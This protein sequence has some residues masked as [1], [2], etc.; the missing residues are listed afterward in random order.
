MKFRDQTS[1]LLSVVIMLL[2][3]PDNIMLNVL[4]IMPSLER[5]FWSLNFIPSCKSA[6][7]AQLVERQAFNLNVQGSSPCSGG[8]IFF[9]FLIWNKMKTKNNFPF[10]SNWFRKCNNFSGYIYL[11][12]R[13]QS[14][15]F[16]FNGRICL[17][18]TFSQHCVY[19]I[20]I[21]LP[22]CNILC[23]KDN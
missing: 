11:F 10:K 21:S 1:V 3:Y 15:L 2:C 16:L 13:W 20:K 18:L 17:L 5:M 6:R 14:L 12:V 7:V 8:T 19:D 23:K 22:A 4:N 9:F